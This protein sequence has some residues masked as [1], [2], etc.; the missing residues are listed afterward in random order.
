[1]SDY[2][3]IVA[4]SLTGDE[5]TKVK[6]INEALRYGIAPEAI[7]S[8]ID[9]VFVIDTNEGAT[10]LIE[11]ISRLASLDPADLLLV[12]NAPDADAIVTRRLNQKSLHFIANAVVHTEKS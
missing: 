11:R 5:A 9:G 1:M 3:K 8:E 2:L 12:M 10:E 7:W 6:S 4:F